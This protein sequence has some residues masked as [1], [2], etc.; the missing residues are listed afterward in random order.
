MGS[1]ASAG[2]SNL[3]RS[4]EVLAGPPAHA[5]LSAEIDLRAGPRVCFSAHLGGSWHGR[6]QHLNTAVPGLPLEHLVAD[7][8]GLRQLRSKVILVTDL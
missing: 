8:A 1:S 7:G 3:E 5:P 4:G 2:S 6:L